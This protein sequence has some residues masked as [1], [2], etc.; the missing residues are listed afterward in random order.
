MLR[1]LASVVMS[2]G[3]CYRRLNFRSN[4]CMNRAEF[5]VWM[6]GSCKRHLRLEQVI[7]CGHMSGQD[8]PPAA[9]AIL[10]R[11]IETLQAEVTSLRS[12]EAQVAGLNAALDASRGEA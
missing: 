9:L 1:H 2:F 4:A 6:P 10:A 12:V 3:S 8:S 5:N 7:G 11:H